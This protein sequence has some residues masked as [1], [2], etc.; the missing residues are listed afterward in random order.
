MIIV[1]SH[2]LVK[3]SAAGS[4]SIF[5]PLLDLTGILVSNEVIHVGTQVSKLRYR[6]NW[7]LF[8]EGGKTS[9]RNSVSWLVGLV[10]RPAPGRHSDRIPARHTRDGVV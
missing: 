5:E 4:I 7:G 6:Y 8:W 3:K 1:L 2:R 10:T 9:V